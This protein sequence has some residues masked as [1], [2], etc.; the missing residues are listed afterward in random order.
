MGLLPLVC[1]ILAMVSG[2][3]YGFGEQ[4][5]AEAGILINGETGAVLWEKNA[6]EVRYPASITKVAT[7][8]Y[9]IAENGEFLE[10]EVEAQWDSV[11]SITTAE[12]KESHYAYPPYWLESGASHMGIKSGERFILRDLL[13]GMMVASANDGANVIGR[14]LGGSVKNYMVEMNAYLADLGCEHTHFLN[15]SGLHHPR[16]VTTARDMA[17]I[18]QEALRYPLFREIVGQSV[19]RRP[20]T[21]KQESTLLAQGNKLL[22]PGPHRYAPAIG[23][24]TGYT[25][26][27]K[28]TFMSAAQG[29]GR[30]LLLVLLGVEKRDHMFEDSIATFETFLREPQKQKVALPKGLQRYTLS[31]KEGNV[32]LQVFCKEE[33]LLSY[34]ESEKPLLKLE[35]QWKESL[36]VPIEKG[37][38]VG[39]AHVVDER[40]AVRASQP[41]YAYKKVSQSWSVWWK[42]RLSF[43]SFLGKLLK[44]AVAL[45][46]LVLLGALTLS[47][48]RRSS[49]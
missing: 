19:W 11:A 29:N 42:E 39:W 7:A 47:F 20:Q 41:L 46:V 32:P 3:L 15:P 49:F 18:G 48:G 33:S 36:T 25:S 45:T 2:S 6:D 28:N 35:L 8:L 38:P 26:D 16:H 5:R 23:I 1:V 17:R 27:A 21:N 14:Y 13:H 10:E 12:K 44:V 22:R 31:L 37:E 9:A 30:T 24:K 4:M 40:G 34:Y 43:S